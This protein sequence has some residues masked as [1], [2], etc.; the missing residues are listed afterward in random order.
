MHLASR[1]EC[2]VPGVQTH[3]ID[4]LKALLDQAGVATGLLGGIG[5]ELPA[6][7]MCVQI[8]H[9]VR[10]SSFVQ[11]RRSTSL[12]PTGGLVI[13]IDDCPSWQ[14]VWPICLGKYCTGC[15]SMANPC[16]HT[17]S[18]GLCVLVRAIAGETVKGGGSYALAISKPAR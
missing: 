10:A 9:A 7:A 13:G 12:S 8:E 5:V 1:Q 2:G 3:P 15:S 4:V 11:M 18:E 6:M 16:K 17:R 14:D